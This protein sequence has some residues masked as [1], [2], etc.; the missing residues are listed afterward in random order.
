MSSI[1]D[2]MNIVSGVAPERT[3]L[4]ESQMLTEA[5]N[6]D[7]MFSKLAKFVM[8]AKPARS[9]S[10]SKEEQ[11]ESDAK[12]WPPEKR[13]TY[14]QE[15]VT[16]YAKEEIQWARKT[17]KRNDRIVWYLRFVR[18][19]III[20]LMRVFEIEPFREM[21]DAEVKQFEKNSKRNY[22]AEGVGGNTVLYNEIDRAARNIPY[23][24]RQLE[25]YMS[26]ADKIAK[27]HSYVFAWQPASTVFD[28]LG[29]FEKQWREERQGLIPVENEHG[30]SD[31]IY[32]EFTDGFAWVLLNRASC[33]EEGDAMGHC[34]NAGSPQ[35]GDRILSLR[36]KVM[37]DNAV[38]WR[39]SLTFILHKDGM[40][41][42][43]KGR[44][45]DKPSEKYHR[46]IISLLESD[47]VKGIQGGGYMPENNFSMN[48]LKPEEADALMEKKPTLA[49]P[50]YYYK[51]NGAD[52]TLMKM[53]RDRGVGTR[54]YR[55]E[56]SLIKFSD[57]G[58]TA[59]LAEF[60]NVSEFVDYYGS[61]S[62]K[63]VYS[64]VDGEYLDIDSSSGKDERSNVWDDVPKIDK[65][66]IGLYLLANEEDAVREWCDAEGYEFEEFDPADSDDVL[67]VIEH[68]ED[69][70]S[71]A[72]D[73]A[74][75]TGVETGAES[76]L[77]DAVDS[78]LKERWN[79]VYNMTGFLEYEPSEIAA[80]N[81][82]REKAGRPQGRTGLI[83]D[84]KCYLATDTE[85]FLNFVSDG[86][87]DDFDGY[88][89]DG[90][91]IEIEEPRYGWSGFDEN[92]AVERFKE[93]AP[94]Y[95]EF[96][97]KLKGSEEQS[98]AA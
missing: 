82:E 51:R 98:K 30:E 20:N 31:E 54:L 44:G 3:A 36:K 4:N 2:L 12:E 19:N 39:P 37:I 35:N 46:H 77:Y 16:N 79:L 27:I 71:D 74:Y 55:Y 83:H 93:E 52:E 70:W 53:V 81:A 85:G 22:S 33:E 89:E 23:L 48:D 68:M 97:K 80:R 59:Y 1:R 50:L 18:L 49:T 47:I 10:F 17:L 13:Q 60:K 15:H 75:H 84:T 86:I 6:Y 38:H 28:D 5:Q 25:H 95:S 73:S 11:A 62:A 34:G 69:A 41:G 76:E 42:E 32:M 91:E 45:N 90:E 7:D 29:H 88:F 43:M 26:Y 24:H 94:D 72:L 57:D 64:V 14:A 21:F 66:A 9:M 63:R 67:G 78:T 96:L 58:K 87:T 92:A 8:V 40:L 56:P 61:D 65:H